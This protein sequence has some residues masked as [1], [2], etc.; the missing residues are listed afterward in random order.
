LN[1]KG[2][3]IIGVPEHERFRNGL[4]GVTQAQIGATERSTRPFLL[5]D[6]DRNTDQVQARFSRLPHEFA[7]RAQPDPFSTG[8]VHAECMID[9]A[10]L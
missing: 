8:V 10:R 7:A 5:G 6:V 2:P 1:C 4:D 3:S 9:G